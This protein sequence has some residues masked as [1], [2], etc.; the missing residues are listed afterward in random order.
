MS[1]YFSRDL[2]SSQRLRKLQELNQFLA[3]V[4][5][6]N[7]VKTRWFYEYIDGEKLEI[8]GV[9]VRSSL[10]NADLLLRELRD[11]L[12]DFALRTGSYL[13]IKP[14]PTSGGWV[15]LRAPSTYEFS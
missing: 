1:L 9:R 10:V 6:S 4:P 15:I 2:N 7:L 13:E 3:E 14:Y 11:N 8:L 12:Q 5:F